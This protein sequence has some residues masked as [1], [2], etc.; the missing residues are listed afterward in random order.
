MPYWCAG[1]YTF[2][3]L[4]SSVAQSE[5]NVDKRSSVSDGGNEI[6]SD[7]GW[8][9]EPSDQIPNIGRVIFQ[10]VTP[11]ES[12]RAIHSRPVP[13]DLNPSLREN[14]LQR[15]QQAKS[16]APVGPAS[17]T[18]LVRALKN[19][20]DLIYEYVR[21]NI[22]Y[23][24]VWGIQKGPLG[25]ILDRQGTAFDQAALMVNLLREAGFTASYVLGQINL[26]ATQVGEWL[27]V[28][29][30][31][32]CAVRQLLANGQV[33]HIA[34]GASSYTCPGTPVALVSIKL[35]HVWVKVNISGTN[36]YFDP[37]FKP[38]TIKIGINLTSA[39]GYNAATYLSQARSGATITADYIQGA[40]RTNIRNNLNAYATTLANYLRTNYPAGTLDDIIGGKT[41]VPYTGA[42]L[43]QTSLPYQDMSVPLTEWTGYIPDAYK[44]TLRIQYQGIDVTYQSHVIYST[45]L[46]ITY[47]SLNRP[48]LM[49]DGTVMATGNPIAPG[50]SGPITFTITH[51]AYV[52]S[53][54]NETFTQQI[55]AGGTY[56]IGNGWGPGGRGVVDLHRQRLEEGRAAG[57]ADTSEVIMGSSLAALSSS[58]IAQSRII[59]DIGDRLANANTT[60]H[61]QVGIAGYYSAAYVD[62]PGNIVSITNQAEDSAKELTAFYNLSTHFSIFESTTVQQLSNNSAVS[63]VKLIDIAAL[64]NY[65]IY[66][67]TSSNYS[68]GTNIQSLLVAC[69]SPQKT[70][71]QNA[72]SS[73]RRLI[74]ASHCNLNENS[75]TG[76]GYYSIA[77]G[78]VRISAIIDGNLAGGFSSSPQPPA[79]YV[80]NTFNNTLSPAAAQYTIGKVFGEPIDMKTGNYLYSSDDMKVGVGSYPHAL[81][82]QKIYSS[83]ARAQ[84]G[85][86]GKGWSHNLA[87]SV[88]VSSDG[89][90]GMGEDS[91]LD[92]VN[93]L[94]EQMVSFDLLSD[95][96]K[97]L[98]K[99]VIATLGQRWF[100]D[101]LLDNTVIVRQGLNGEVFVKLPDGTYNPPP[102]N[103]VRLIKN[104]DGTYTYET[105][106]RDKLNFNSAGKIATYNHAN[107]LQVKYTYTGDNLTQ[108]QNSL[109]RTLTFT[110]VSGRITA[111]GDGSRSIGY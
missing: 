82:F 104:G 36:Y 56:L 23:Y 2:L 92:A 71:F 7:G 91:A 26:N 78:G 80:S 73:G 46:T 22:G 59:G 60:Y 90:Q 69:S 27:G 41:I 45:R 51:S 47:N 4:F 68:T 98:D 5:E 54:A 16:T 8:P 52:G 106:N 44:P 42:P 101:Q 10:P 93:T 3:I 76:V 64:N 87:S 9:R 18:E 20:P 1:F 65:R 95:T 72:I 66:D 33:P 89:F 84:A 15:A 83:G 58:W 74:L 17:T 40:N 88:F 43:R 14:A 30:N 109:G 34:V 35:S 108:V 53:G 6:S 57:S 29:T 85:P 70:I 96:A 38:H 28:D 11:E 37:S 63:T 97:P 75:W 12:E 79:P 102:A 94:V 77:P 50:T 32:I 49:L 100:G 25:T 105:V 62:L 21:N 111:V 19:D 31:N 110:Y 55:K 48:V 99:L 13:P 86:L 67:A 24:P 103:S 107:G 39:S 81:A 61:H